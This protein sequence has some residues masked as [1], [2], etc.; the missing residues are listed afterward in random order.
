MSYFFITGT[1]RSGTT[2]L[3]KLIGVD[4]RFFSLE[5]PLPTA[6]IYL[7]NNFMRSLGY[8]DNLPLGTFFNETRY[9]YEDFTNYLQKYY[10]SE[11]DIDEIFSLAE[12]FDGVKTKEV[13]NIKGQLP[14]NI[15]F[16]EFYKI[17]VSALHNALEPDSSPVFKGS[18]EIISEEYIEYFLENNV[19][20][21]LIIRDVRDVI[22]SANF[23]KG[24]KYMGSIRPTLFTI[25]VWRKSVGIALHFRNNPLFL[26]IKYE[27]LVLK[28]EET[29]KKIYDFFELS[30]PDINEIYDH[31]ANSWVA[32]SSFGQYRG[33]S[34]Q[35]I[36]K[37]KN[38][39]PENYTRYIE[40][41]SYPEMKT[42]NYKTDFIQ[43][44]DYTAEKIK[45]A[46]SQFKE[47]VDVNHKLFEKDYSF[48]QDNKQLEL[49]RHNALINE[50][51]SGVR[52]FFIFEDTYKQLKKAINERTI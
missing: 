51:F 9:R 48:S 44:K 23:G 37:Y 45:Q 40:L 27:D 5:Q 3:Q 36:G 21:L 2:L 39:F 52:Q 12:N 24:N 15:P 43:D 8:R 47:P 34:A 28:T 49:E 50:N 26:A 20:T 18:K 14:Q 46:F 7:K 25:R 11:K 13:F 31:L 19:K 41:M 1:Y 16:I 35:S 33:L 4:N 42:T 22:N 30:M 32:N 38:N 6:Y 17:Y 10:I 29:L